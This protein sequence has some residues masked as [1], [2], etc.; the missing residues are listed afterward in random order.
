MFKFM[1]FNPEPQVNS[2]VW[3]FKEQYLVLTSPPM[4]SRIY[5]NHIQF[6]DTGTLSDVFTDSGLF[7]NVCMSVYSLRL[8]FMAL[9]LDYRIISLICVPFYLHTTGLYQAE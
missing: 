1:L 9:L 2:L 3:W 5:K 8:T 4:I 6:I 7:I